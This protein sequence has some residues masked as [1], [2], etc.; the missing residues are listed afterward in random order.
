[1]NEDYLFPFPTFRPKQDELLKEIYDTLS[2]N[3]QI[4]V[5]APTGVGKTISGLG[6]SLSFALKNN[7]KI[8]YL[9][10][11]KTQVNQVLRTIELINKKFNLNLKATGFTG[12]SDMCVH[13]KKP[14]SGIQDFCNKKVS[15]E[16]CEFYLNYK[17]TNGTIPK[18]LSET[19]AFNMEDYISNCESCGYCPHK[20]SYN[21]L[22][23]SN[24]VIGDYNY[25]FQK[26]IKDIIFEMGTFE[27][28]K[29]ILIV[30]EAHNLP[31]RVR[32][33]FS[34]SLSTQMIDNAIK[35]VNDYIQIFTKE[36]EKNRINNYLRNIK[37]FLFAN[38]KESLKDQIKDSHEELVQ[39]TLFS[40]LFKN[41][42]YQT[43]VNEIKIKGSLIEGEVNDD[44]FESSL[45]K[46]GD[47]LDFWINPIIGDSFIRYAKYKHIL[48]EKG[49]DDFI[50]SI[51]VKNLDPSKF[52]KEAVE[53]V[54]GV[55]MLSA[56]L[57]PI[58]K[59][60]YDLGLSKAKV[61][62]LPSPFKD[63]NVK[64]IFYSG[65]SFSS[66][67]SQRNDDGL[68]KMNNRILDIVNKL[69][70]NTIVFFPSY[71]YLNLIYKRFYSEINHNK[72]KIHLESSEM[73]KK[74]KEEVVN[75]FENNKDKVQILFG[76]SKG[77]FYEGL[78]LPGKKLE[79][80]ILAGF[81]YP[82]TD[83]VNESL[84]KYYFKQ[85]ISNAKEYT[86]IFPAIATSIQA[87][88]RCIRDDED[89]G[90]IF[91]LDGRFYQNKKY[92]PPHW[93]FEYSPSLEDL[94]KWF[95]E[96]QLK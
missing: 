40:D 37:N 70:K 60:Q 3:G 74:E 17:E 59:Y 29:T 82:P 63:E 18:E 30:D 76:V 85:G 96:Y 24:V 68:N 26:K 23:F 33:Y 49:E 54:F 95:E 91:L 46:V 61:K 5:S 14:N 2:E 73:S 69:E 89:R 48:T 86:Y 84:E 90:L 43:V 39:K 47:F 45:M 65:E 36:E 7:L 12:K 44:E 10:S 57:E 15:S 1:M 32:S 19:F 78:D 87:G 8:I 50:G 72:F 6:P 75:A 35:E 11:R 21:K 9:T 27:E 66:K 62:I 42:K 28:N 53:N 31:D 92:L 67:I 93:K 77:N 16:N 52:I 51:N 38:S 4:L 20:M 41:F 83:L 88:G 94:K 81:P 13:K 80:V 34:K 79:V 56:T 22:R 64:Y 58:E 71:D 25:F 55:V